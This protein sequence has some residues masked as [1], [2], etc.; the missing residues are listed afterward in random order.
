MFSQIAFENQAVCVVLCMCVYACVL[1]LIALL[2][3]SEE[4][5]H[6]LAMSPEELLLRW[7]N[8]HLNAA[9]WRQ[10][11][12]FSEDIKVPYANKLV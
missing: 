6:L 3:E 5:E 12:N 7:V 1:A 8:Y 10:I 9:G 2:G 11:R 4:L